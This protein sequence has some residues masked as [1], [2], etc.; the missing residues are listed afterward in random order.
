MRHVKQLLRSNHRWTALALTSALLLLSCSAAVAQDITLDSAQV[1]LHRS[2]QLNYQTLSEG[3]AYA[4]ELTDTI[5]KNNKGLVLAV[6]Y[7]EQFGQHFRLH[8]LILFKDLQSYSTLR[9]K[10]MQDSDFLGLAPASNWGHLFV[11]SS[12]KDE[13]IVRN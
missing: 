5:N 8:W 13:V 2:A 3:Q 11:Q 10:L 12:I 1:I 9:T 7:E 4:R 6:M